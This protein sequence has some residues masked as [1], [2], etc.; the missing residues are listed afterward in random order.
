MSWL[1]RLFTTKV[2]T[3]QIAGVSLPPEQIVNFATGVSGA[4]N[5]SNGRVDLTVV[6]TIGTGGVTIDM[7]DTD[8]V[9]LAAEYAKTI[10]TNGS[11]TP[12]T[13]SKNLQL[14]V[15]AD[16]DTRA[17]FIRNTNGAANDVVCYGAAGF[18][19]TTVTVPD[20]FS[21]WVGVNTAGCFR[22]GADVAN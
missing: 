4:D 21:A 19:G 14:P 12:M 17:W 22:M 16:A 20:G 15:T 18:T 8:Y 6:G 9:L 3:I 2:T 7:N 10:I 5:P 1:D 11:A 13:G